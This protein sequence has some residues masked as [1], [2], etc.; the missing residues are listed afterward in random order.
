MSL[1]FNHGNA[2]Q[3]MEQPAVAQLH[4]I[5]INE[6]QQCKLNYYVNIVQTNVEF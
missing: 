3:A 5:R 4:G 1:I 2:D 6:K